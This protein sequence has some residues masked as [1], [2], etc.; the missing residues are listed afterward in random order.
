[1]AFDSMLF[2]ARECRAQGL[3]CWF[4]VVDCIGEDEIARCRAVAES[5]GIPLRVRPMIEE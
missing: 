4:S 5:V 2:F 1:M 3:N